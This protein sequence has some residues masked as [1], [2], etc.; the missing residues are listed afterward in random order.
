MTAPAS[1]LPDLQKEFQLCTHE[2]QGM[3]LGGLSQM[4]GEIPRPVAYV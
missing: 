3:A 4:P 2:R 1:G